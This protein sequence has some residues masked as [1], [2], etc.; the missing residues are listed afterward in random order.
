MYKAITEIQAQAA[1]GGSPAPKT[2]SN[3]STPLPKISFPEIK[4]EPT[5][6]E[7]APPPR[8]TATSLTSPQQIDLSAFKDA[9]ESQKAEYC[10]LTPHIKTELGRFN[11]LIGNLK[12]HLSSPPPT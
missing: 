8:I 5:K 6:L 10:T 4:F 11:E 12:Q 2:P 3:F 7:V 9:I 1:K